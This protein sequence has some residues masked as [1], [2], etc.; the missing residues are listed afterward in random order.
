MSA[1]V[2]FL[3][4]ADLHLGIPV[5]GFSGASKELESRLLQASFETWRRICDAALAYDVDFVLIAGDVYHQEA[6]SV[7]AARCLQEGVRR[8]G[9]AGIEVYA[10]YGNHDFLGERHELLDMPE[11]FHACPADEPGVYEVKKGGVTAARILG[12]SYKSRRESRPLYSMLR[13][14]DDAVIN[15]GLLHTALDP[16]NRNYVPCSIQDL[17]HQQYMDYWAL[18]H[19]HQPWIIR[20]GL[21]AIAFPGTPQGRHPG[22]RGVGGCLLVELGPGKVGEIRFIPISP[23]V[24]MELDVA[25]D[26]PWENEPIG[27]LSDLERLL[28]ARAEELLQGETIMPD[29]PLADPGWQPEGYLVRWVLTGRGPVHELL[30]GAEEEIDE[31]LYCLRDLQEREPFLWT[32]SIQVQTGPALPQWEAMLE[33]WPL[34]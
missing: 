5:Q 4:T 10:V 1:S 30:T 25:V 15:I 3:H 17:L 21:P 7:K 28:V 2:R 9:E 12:V 13:P 20:S 32:E 14:P 33:S 6:R 24:W 22:E 27:N 23:F 34:V 11:N 16:Q 26:E 18:G 31:L 19:V 8:L 29:I